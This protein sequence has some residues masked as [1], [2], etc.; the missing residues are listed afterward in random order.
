MWVWKGRRE[1][2]EGYREVTLPLRPV[3]RD[4]SGPYDLLATLVALRL[5]PIRQIGSLE[6]GKRD[7]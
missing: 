1:L 6:L 2:G 7:K 4:K 3:G 5:M